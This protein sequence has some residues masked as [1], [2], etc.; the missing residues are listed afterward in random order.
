MDLSQPELTKMATRM[1]TLFT[2]RKRNQF[3]N[4]RL[5][6]RQR[7]VEFWEKSALAC[8]EA[9]ADP[10]DWIEAAFIYNTVGGGPYAQT[11]HGPAMRRWYNEYM[12]KTP[13][14]EAVGDVKSRVKFDFEILADCVLRNNAKPINEQQTLEQLLIDQFNK[15]APYVAVVVLPK[16]HAVRLKYLDRARKIISG[17]LAY[18]DAIDELGYDTEIITNANITP[19]TEI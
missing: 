19:F 11:L 2:N 18:L 13:D 1:R 14:G 6:E 17:S 4:F 10:R 15:I 3:P 16:S 5:N 9:G 7:K 8:Y 12:Q